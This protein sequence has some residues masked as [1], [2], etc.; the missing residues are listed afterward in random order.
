[1]KV[2]LSGTRRGWI[3]SA[4]SCSW[5][6]M[7]LMV[8][9]KWWM[10]EIGVDRLWLTSYRCR[11]TQFPKL[12]NSNAALAPLLSSR[13]ARVTAATHFYPAS[14]DRV[15]GLR[16]LSNACPLTPCNKRDYEVWLSVV[17]SWIMGL[18]CLFAEVNLNQSQKQLS[19]HT[20][21]RTSSSRL[22]NTDPV[23]PIVET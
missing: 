20:S 12:L 17:T 4:T 6:G 8:L 2:S 21:E 11:A 22:C 9:G 16:L 15:A 3:P 14:C 23:G 5:G 19:C 18:W 7:R 1:M 10:A 13:E